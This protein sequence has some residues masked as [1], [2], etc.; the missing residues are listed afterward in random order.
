MRALSLFSPGRGPDGGELVETLLRTASF[1]LERIV[2]AG[3]A[4][5]PG[6][7]YD[8]DTAEWVVLLSGRARLTFEGEPDPV[9]LGPGDYILIPAHTRH[10]VEETDPFQASIWL[11]LHY[12][13]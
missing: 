12:D 1:R 3:H 5:P 4:T 2:S 9:V 13:V 11:A 7:W 6:E 8:Q 10:R